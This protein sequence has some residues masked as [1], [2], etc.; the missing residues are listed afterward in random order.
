M[1]GR[2]EIT[3]DGREGCERFGEE[4]NGVAAMLEAEC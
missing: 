4:E 2:E 3:F 1:E